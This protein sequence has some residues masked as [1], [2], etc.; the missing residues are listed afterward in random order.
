M[1]IA[2]KQQPIVDAVQSAFRVGPDMGSLKNGQDA[3]TGNC[4]PAFIGISH[5]K[6]KRSLPKARANRGLIAESWYL[7]FKDLKI[8]QGRL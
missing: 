7:N 6:A 3:L 2:A 4:A 8:T 1:Q 5:Q